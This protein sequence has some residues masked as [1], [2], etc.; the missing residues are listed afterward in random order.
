MFY[1]VAALGTIAAL[2]SVGLSVEAQT[3]PSSA[4]ADVPIPAF[5]SGCT[6]LRVVGG[7]GTEVT[8]ST[9][10]PGIPIPLPIGGI[11]TRSNWNTDWV[12]PSNQSFRRFIV[13]IMPRGN[14]KY[15]IAMY[16]KYADDTVDKFYDHG[17]IDLTKDHP[18]TVSD[19]PRAGMQPYQVNVRVGG[20]NSLGVNYSAAVAACR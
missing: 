7:E 20:L 16:L 6:P 4:P 12:V 11:S 10:A 3:S 19:E 13:T 2:L 5:P 17:S 18:L 14:S 8:K 1:R 9:S 15:N